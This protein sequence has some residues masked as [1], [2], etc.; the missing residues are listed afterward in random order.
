MRLNRSGPTSFD[1]ER[2]RSTA[3]VDFGTC[4]PAALRER[5]ADFEAR[6]AKLLQLAREARAI[7]DMEE[8]RQA[9]VKQC[10]AEERNKKAAATRARKADPFGF[11]I[12]AKD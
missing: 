11:K 3:T 1:V 10:A 5:A 2:E 7:A 4:D 12:L 8:V 9:E 6:A